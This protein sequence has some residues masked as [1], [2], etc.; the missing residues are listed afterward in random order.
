V[1]L[2]WR[3]A[4]WPGHMQVQADVPEGVVCC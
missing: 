2:T 4:G 3:Q 1:W